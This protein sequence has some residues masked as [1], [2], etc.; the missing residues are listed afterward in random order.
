MA[1]HKYDQEGGYAY[2]PGP[3][4]TWYVVET[5]TVELLRFPSGA[6]FSL[7][8]HHQGYELNYDSSSPPRYQDV[9]ENFMANFLNKIQIEASRP[10]DKY[11]PTSPNKYRPTS[12][13]KYPHTRSN[14]YLW[15]TSPNKYQHTSPYKYRHTSPLRCHPTSP[16]K[17]RP[18][19]PEKYRHTSPEKY[20]HTSPKNYQLTSPNRYRYTSPGKYTSPDKYHPTS[21]NKYHPTN[22]DKYR[23]TSP[24]K[25]RHT[26]PNQ[27]QLT[28]PNRHQYTSPD[29]YRHT[30]PMHNYPSKEA[31]GFWP[32]GLSTPNKHHTS[33]PGQRIRLGKHSGLDNNWHS[34]AHHPLTPPTNDINE[35]LGFLVESLNYSGI[36]NLS[37]NAQ[38]IEHERR[39]TSR[40]F[41]GATTQPYATRLIVKKS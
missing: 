27:Y 25:Y 39:Y 32:Q 28:S 3:H 37:L 6:P 14:K 15:P 35:A 11:R 7:K 8:D 33:S 22:P 31:H 4:A 26:G 18:T 5:T 9:D 1:R 10:T 2:G 23:D 36:D 20:P 21:S 16:K 29:K 40:A 38:S 41:R 13:N 24:D 19:S 30:S 34:V 12:P 17:Y